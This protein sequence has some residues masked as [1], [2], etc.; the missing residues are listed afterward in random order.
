VHVSVDFY[1]WDSIDR[2]E[3]SFGSDSFSFPAEVD[4]EAFLSCTDVQLDAGPYTW[5]IETD[6]SKG[7]YSLEDFEVEKDFRDDEAPTP[8]HTQAI[9]LFV[10]HSDSTHFRV[11]GGHREMPWAR[12]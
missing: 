4:V 6:I 9:P 2:E 5:H 11:G 1:I 8:R 3:M 7:S 12:I 10:T